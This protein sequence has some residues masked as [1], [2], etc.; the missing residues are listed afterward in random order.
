MT[1]YLFLREYEEQKSTGRII[2]PDT[3][4]EKP[5]RGKVVDAGPGKMERDEDMY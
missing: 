2:A 5:R 3:P 4:K 1:I